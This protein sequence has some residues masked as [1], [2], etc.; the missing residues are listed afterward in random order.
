MAIPKEESSNTGNALLFV[1][2]VN[3]V[4]DFLAN[5]NEDTRG[6][7]SSHLSTQM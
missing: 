3:T 1:G 6:A 2:T 4:N 7:T 5:S